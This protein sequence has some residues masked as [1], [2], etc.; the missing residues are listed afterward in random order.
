MRTPAPEDLAGLQRLRSWLVERLGGPWPRTTVAVESIDQ[1]RRS[2][3]EV[4][5]IRFRGIRG[6]WVPAYALVPLGATEPLPTVVTLHQHNGQFELG[7]SE[8]AGMTGDPSANIAQRLAEAGFFV[9]A[10]DAVAF[11]ERRGRVQQGFFFER[12]V[13]MEELLH[14][15]CLAWRMVGDVMCAIDALSAF[16]PA[17][18]SRLGLIGHSMGGTLT[19]FAAALDARVKAAVVNCGLASLRSVLRDEVIHCYLNYVPGL[20]PTCDHAQIAALVAPRALLISAG[21]DDRGFPVDGVME[22][23]EYARRTF[24]AMRVPEKIHLH[25]EGCGHAFTESMH[26]AALWW[27]RRWL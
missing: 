5:Y 23:F 6:D 7:K 11:E 9:L 25:V 13:A 14:G 22:T 24:A 10:P 12:F 18:V 21:A 20:L 8:V 16:P 2:R 17:N 26:R 15:R 4:R 27:L 1:W 19:L 3:H